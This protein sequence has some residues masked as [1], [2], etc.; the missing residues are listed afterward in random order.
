MQLYLSLGLALHE[1]K[2][3]DQ[4]L[5]MYDKAIEFNPKNADFYFRKGKHLYL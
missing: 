5:V 4:A 1:I 2:K 3:Y